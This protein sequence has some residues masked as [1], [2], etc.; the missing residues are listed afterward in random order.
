ME[1]KTICVT[2]PW[3]GSV[4]VMTH[5]DILEHIH[6]VKAP[7]DAYDFLH[8]GNYRKEIR[9]GYSEYDG[10]ISAVIFS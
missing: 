9:A 6:N 10:A 3:T 7:R 2:N 1:K 5:S 4:R 8:S